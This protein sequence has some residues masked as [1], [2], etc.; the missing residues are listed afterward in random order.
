[1]GSQDSSTKP[2]CLKTSVFVATE[3]GIFKDTVGH[4]NGFLCL[5]LTRG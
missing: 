4:L 3:L 2:G 5:N 1:M